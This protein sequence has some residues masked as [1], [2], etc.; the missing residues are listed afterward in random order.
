MIPVPYKVR[1][2][3]YIYVGGTICYLFHIRDG[4]P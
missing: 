3:P 4:G 1:E 2:G